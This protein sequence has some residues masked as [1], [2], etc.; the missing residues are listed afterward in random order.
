MTFEYQRSNSLILELSTLQES[1]IGKRTRIEMSIMAKQGEN[2]EIEWESLR[3]C[4]KDIDALSE[5]N[6]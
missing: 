3:K 2:D 4:R 1:L 6:F 5:E